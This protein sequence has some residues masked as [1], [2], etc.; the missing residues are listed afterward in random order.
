M[1][2]CE[3]GLKFDQIEN[4]SFLQKCQLTVLYGAARLLL[5]S[6]LYYHII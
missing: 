2:R 3:Q 4:Y 6:V 5:I 1:Y